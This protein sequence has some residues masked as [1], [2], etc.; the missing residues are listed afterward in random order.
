MEHLVNA[1]NRFLRLSP[2]D[3]LRRH[4]LESGE[5]PYFVSNLNIAL[6]QLSQICFKPSGSL[7]FDGFEK[8]GL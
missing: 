2:H 5:Q 7:I 4:A 8:Q 3:R 6:F 1:L